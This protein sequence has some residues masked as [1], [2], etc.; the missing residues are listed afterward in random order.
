MRITLGGSKTFD[1]SQLSTDKQTFF[2]NEC[3]YVGYPTTMVSMSYVLC[4]LHYILK[5]A[6]DVHHI[7]SLAKSSLN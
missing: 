3:I 7:T 1:R 4:A 5:N 2:Q 6:V